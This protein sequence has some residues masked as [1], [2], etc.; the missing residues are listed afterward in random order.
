MKEI[1]LI[2]NFTNEQISWKENDMKMKSRDCTKNDLC[3]VKDL[4]GVDKVVG[5]LAG[6]DYK[7]YGSQI[8]K[9]R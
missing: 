5:Q 6:N 7:N 8:Q 2:I 4:K 1:C 9:D 3:S